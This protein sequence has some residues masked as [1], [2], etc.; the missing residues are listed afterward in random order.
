[1]KIGEFDLAI[2]DLNAILELLEVIPENDKKD[3]FYLRVV[4]KVYAKLY[5]L[6]AIKGDFDNAILN[7]DLL[8]AQNLFLDD[9]LLKIVSNDKEMIIKRKESLLNKVL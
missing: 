2:K 7:A 1:M 4:I 6:Y 9:K 8:L 5:A 3:N